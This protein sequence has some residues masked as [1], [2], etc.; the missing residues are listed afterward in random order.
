MVNNIYAPPKSVVAE[1]NR[2]NFT[3]GKRLLIVASAAWSA[4]GGILVFMFIREFFPLGHGHS[5]TFGVTN[6][7]LVIGSIFALIGGV[8]SGFSSRFGPPL[9]FC[10]FFALTLNT[11]W[12]GLNLSNEE[13]IKFVLLGLS[14]VFIWY[15]NAQARK[16]S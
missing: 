7:T 4:L 13:I 16:L 3:W 15:M 10:S 2:R 8:L 14:V 12:G 11:Q 1:V 9:L 6:V 5:F